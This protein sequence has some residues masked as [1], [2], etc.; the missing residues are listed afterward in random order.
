VLRPAPVKELRSW[1]AA[2]SGLLD[3]QFVVMG[4]GGTHLCLRVGVVCEGVC[5]GPEVPDLAGAQLEDG[6]PDQTGSALHCPTRQETHMPY[7][8]IGM[9]RQVQGS[10]GRLG[11]WSVPNVGRTYL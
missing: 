2:C 1:A 5:P 7:G 11:R 9:M 4:R 8:Q 10:M 6:C 3:T